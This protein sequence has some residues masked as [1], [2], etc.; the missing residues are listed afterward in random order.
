[1]EDSDP[2][3]QPSPTKK[4]NS[5]PKPSNTKGETNKRVPRQNQVQAQVDQWQLLGKVLSTPVTL[6]VGEVFGM[7]KE[8]SHHLQEILKPVKSPAASSKHVVAT[9]FLPRT[10]GILIHLRMEIDDKP[11]MAIIDTGS[12]LNIASRRIW[13]TLIHRP[14]DVA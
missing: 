4:S 10:K 9:A 1:M 8:M 2:E 13:K 6:Q 14:M 12:Q 11:I 3:D 5:T 7:S